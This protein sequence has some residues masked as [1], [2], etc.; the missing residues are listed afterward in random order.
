MDRILTTVN[1]S[2]N[3]ED[4][5]F[6][7]RKDSV[8]DCS[9]IQQIFQDGDYDLAPFAQNSNVNPFYVSLLAS[10]K[11]PLIVDAGA[12]IGASVVYFSGMFPGSRILAIEPEANNCVLLRK[13]CEGLNFV[14]LE[15]GIGNKNGNLFLSDPG[16]SDWGFRVQ[17]QGEFPVRVFGAEEAIDA[18]MSLGY[19]PFI[20][21]IDIEG[22]ESEL[23][24]ENTSWLTRFPLVIIE[25]HDWLLPGKATSRS[26]LQAI[27]ALNFD[28][29]YRGENVFCF[30]NDLL[31][32][33]TEGPHIGT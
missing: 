19:V 15:G 17:D 32:P 23:F 25:L 3:G 29:V 16:Q 18:Q 5:P 12:N 31:L 8:G 27:S 28:F 30:N 24:R 33:G 4:R 22:G 10:G 11:A 2:L 7:F 9:V 14:L 21:K 6:L 1:I 20:F 13:N 26:F